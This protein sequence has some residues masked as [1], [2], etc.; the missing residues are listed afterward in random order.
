MLDLHEYIVTLH[1]KDDLEQFYDDIETTE[2]AVHVYD[3]EPSF[4]KRAVEVTN[5]RLIS[6][7]TH[8]MLTHEEAQE[9]K[10]DPRVWDVELAE[11][12]ELTIKPTGWKMENEKFSKDW[13]A[14]ATDHNWGLLRHSEDANRANWGSN[15]TNTY[16]SDLTVTSSGENVDVV[17]VDGHIDPAHPEFKP[18]NARKGNLINDNTNSA[19][20]DRSVTVNGLKIVISGAAG[21]QIAVPDEWARKTAR[22]VDLMIDPD[23]SN[24]NSAYQNNLIATLRGDVGTVHAGL[25]AVQRVAYGG[26]N[27]YEPNFLE[28]AGISS[29]VG[30]QAF[31]DSH[32]HNDMVWYR[33]VS[34]PS[35]SVG[36]RDI[37]EIVE[38]LMHTIHLMGVMGAVPS[39]ETDMNWMA[40]DNVNWKTTALH[41]AMKEAIDGSFFD[42]SGYASDWATVA[43]AAEVAYKE[44]LYLLNWGMWEMSEFWDGGSLAPEWSD[45]M[46]TASGIQTN[47]PLG[48]ALFNTYIDPVLTKPNFTTLRAIFQNADAGVSGYAPSSRVNQF[49]W[50]SLT[51][52]VSGGSNGTYTY[53]PYIDAGNADRTGDNNHG[54]HCAGTV[55][56]NSQGWARDAT[57]YNISP[58]GSNPN[59]LSSS[60]M[61]DYIRAW[62]NT[63]PINP[64][65]GRRNPT[66][67]NN[68]YGSSIT[69]NYSGS[70]TTGKVTRVNYRGVDFN[71][72]RDLTTQELRDR[73]FYALTLQMDIP[74]FF[75][76]RNADMQDAID[77]GIIIVASAG[78]DYWKTVNA[79]DQDY[80][81]TYNMVYN[82]YDYTWNLH[83]GTG[84]GAGYAPIINVGATSN[85]VN[86]DKAD[87]SNCGNQVDIFAA[88]EGIQSSLLSGGI[89][90]PRDDNYELGK[91][92]GTS[93]SGPQVAGV[94]AILA[95][96]WPNMTQA[97]A[98]QW[99][100]DNANSDQM[101]D[102]EADDPMDVNSLQGAPNKYLRW[103]NQ[104]A[105]SGASFPQKNFRNRPTSGKTYP[106]P[107][108]RRRG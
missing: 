40:T 44:Y 20:F 102:T 56:G 59:T 54:T 25:P 16:V 31:L 49:N 46:R 82:G 100:I 60:L 23:G 11:M 3:I 65:T 53:T 8:Y 42:P 81:N 85:D 9:L 88:G 90:D 4:P 62:H 86:E 27:Q 29:Y 61:W 7:N 63:K 80:N 17:I 103:I 92:Q 104:R 6:R 79:S 108:I 76:S 36:D 77:D 70:Y 91:Y 55:A 67:T 78:N 71:P 69:T 75:T 52:Q 12:I 73:G 74:N 105:I 21:G 57:I 48:Y 13:F 43:D 45:S 39:S 22:V 24:V 1:N 41:L 84:S 38:H 30:Y 33:N 106:R 89:D 34:G 58:Y 101:A 98:Q 97:E 14:D 83:R 51:N 94:L 35:P 26:G 72:G 32:V 87:F 68:S 96:S 18:R 37:E 10:N 2:S 5:R 50:F 93:M 66:I 15:G 99:L 64:K 28:D 19:L 95:E 47:N 107:R